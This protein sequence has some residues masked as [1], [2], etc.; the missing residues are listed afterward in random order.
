MQNVAGIGKS[1]N[2]EGMD[3]MDS[4]ETSGL[5]EGGKDAELRTTPLSSTK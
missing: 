4:I 3:A 5:E 2:A 1:V